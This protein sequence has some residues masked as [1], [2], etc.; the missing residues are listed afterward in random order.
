MHFDS[1]LSDVLSTIVGGVALAFLFFLAKEKFFPVPDLC[2]TWYFEMRTETTAYKPYEGMLLRYVAML[3]RNE[4][5]LCGSVEK[6]YEQSST[7]TRSYTGTNRT[8]GIVQGYIDHKFL[9]R[10]R[11]FLHVV[12]D[13]H[14]RESTNCY[15]VEL[16]PSGKMIGTFTSMVAE[17]G[18]VVTW[19]RNPF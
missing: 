9:D 12:E 1:F 15:N 4:N 3:W 2:G 10:D 14:G 18:G 5:Q 7:G 11:I 17:Q 16:Q 13:G 8:R 19:Q 6:I